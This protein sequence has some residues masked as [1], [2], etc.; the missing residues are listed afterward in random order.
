VVSRCL[1]P[2]LFF[3]QKKKIYKDSIVIYLYQIALESKG[4]PYFVEEGEQLD[5][6]LLHQRLRLH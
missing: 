1:D 4:E 5:Q 6:I 3:F 2:T